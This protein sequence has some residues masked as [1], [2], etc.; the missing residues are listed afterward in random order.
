MEKQ[1]T[2]KGGYLKIHKPKPI[3]FYVIKLSLS[4]TFFDIRYGAWVLAL[5]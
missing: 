4:L 3:G 5:F 1:N 2:R